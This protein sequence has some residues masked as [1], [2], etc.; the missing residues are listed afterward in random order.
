MNTLSEQQLLTIWEIA[1]TKSSIEKTVLLLSTAHKMTEV[2]TITNWSIGYRDSQLLLL[3]ESLFGTKFINHAN[4]PSCKEKLE[5]EMELKDLPLNNESVPVSIPYFFTYDPYYIQ[6]RMPNSLDITN[7]DATSIMNGCIEEARKEDKKIE[8]SEL[9][10]EVL[11]KLGAE[12]EIIEP[13]SNITFAL[14]CPECNHQWSIFFDII[15]Y[16]WVEIDSWAKH[17][18]QEIVALARGFGWTETEI[19]NLSSNRRRL[20]LKMINS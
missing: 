9:P 17:L 13:I 7:P 12:M 11:E 3:R 15:S 6:F 14:S 2:D 10:A 5:W 4:C 16:F 8:P 19:L 18:L 20:Y 1:Q